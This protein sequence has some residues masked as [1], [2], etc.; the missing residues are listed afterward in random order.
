MYKLFFAMCLLEEDQTQLVFLQQSCLSC[1]DA[2]VTAIWQTSTAHSTHTH[3]HTVDDISSLYNRFTMI[4]IDLCHRLIITAPNSCM[5][6]SSCRRVTVSPSAG[7][8]RNSIRRR[9][10]L[11]TRGGTSDAD[12]QSGYLIRIN[13]IKAL[14]FL[15]VSDFTPS[16]DNFMCNTRTNR[17]RIWR[18][19]FPV[20]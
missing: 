6:S 20:W 14:S 13:E 3:T 1:S 9:H 7:W 16:G 4:V 18:N 12:P 10:D 8:S 5:M 2:D 17:L 19:H 11:W 15:F